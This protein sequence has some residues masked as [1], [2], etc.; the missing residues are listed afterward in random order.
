MT[1][2]EHPHERIKRRSGFGRYNQSLSGLRTWK[3]VVN[4]DERRNHV[5]DYYDLGEVADD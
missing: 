4:S 3:G 5:L 1:D 2:D